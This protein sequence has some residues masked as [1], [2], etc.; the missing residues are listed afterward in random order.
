V[1]GGDRPA[2]RQ[3]DLSDDR[4]SC[5]LLH[6]RAGTPRASLMR[7]SLW[8]APDL[9][10]TQRTRFPQGRWKTAQTAVFHTLHRRTTFRGMKKRENET[11]KMIQTS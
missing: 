4:P 6:R 2:M 11:R 1:I 3:V 9:W 10:K 7:G 8:I 5:G